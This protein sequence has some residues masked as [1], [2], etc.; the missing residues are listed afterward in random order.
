MW[1]PLIAAHAA[2]AVLALLVGPVVL[3]RPKGT[4]RHRLLGRAWGLLMVWVALSS[5][6]IMRL[7]PGSLSWIHGLSAFTLVMLVLGWRAA[8]THRIALH[9]RRMTGAY[10]GLLGAFA[11]AVAV[12]QRLVPQLVV[13]RPVLA[14]CGA[15]MIAGAAYLLCGYAGMLSHRPASAVSR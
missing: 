8:V 13:H 14:A 1:T 9:H 3:A 15:T 5:F 7:R 4:R 2:A 10:A 12:P 6:G 11:G